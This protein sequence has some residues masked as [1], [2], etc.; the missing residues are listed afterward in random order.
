MMLWVPITV[1][2]AGVI[3]ILVWR[4][5][6]SALTEVE[7]VTGQVIQEGLA[8]AEAVPAYQVIAVI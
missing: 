6:L 1:P 7:S 2:S 8:A 3:V 4:W 5:V